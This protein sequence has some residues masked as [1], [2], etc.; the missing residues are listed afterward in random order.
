MAHPWTQDDLQEIGDLDRYISCS[1][2]VLAL[3][4]MSYMRSKNCIIELQS[5]VRREKP[6]IMLVE[7][8]PDQGGLT[9]AAVEAELTSSDV[10]YQDWGLDNEGPRGSHLAR[11]LQASP[12]IEWSRL[13]PFQD[14]TM[15]L[16]AEEL[17]KAMPPTSPGRALLKSSQPGWRTVPGLTYLEGSAEL[18]TPV[19]PAPRNGCSF[20]L[21]CSPLLEGVLQLSEE[22]R[23][24]YGS[25]Q[26]QL[27]ITQQPSELRLCDYM[28]V[29]LT[30]NTWQS[31]A[32]SVELAAEV[33][34]ALQ[35]GVALLL[36]H[37]MPGEGQDARHAAEFS[38]FFQ[39]DRGA[40]PPQL[41]RAGIYK[42]VAVF[43]SRHRIPPGVLYTCAHHGVHA[44]RRC[45]SRATPCAKSAWF[46]LPRHSSRSPRRRSRRLLKAIVVLN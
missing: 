27:R 30:A 3:T 20:H 15:R 8:N 19:L 39:C 35:S 1:S 32:A 6:L 21:Y 44:P 37:E 24:H 36:A 23:T 38:D 13:S 33:A 28:L 4:T 25:T 9:T 11:A 42:Q 14:V 12:A 31:G 26:Q 41:I 7:D 40:T 16:I 18:E 45:H 46:S 5:A 2:V 10:R 43:A 22:L 17:L 34:A 29:Y